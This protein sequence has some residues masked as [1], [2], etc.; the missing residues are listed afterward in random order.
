MITHTIDINCRPDD[1]FA[2]REQLEVAHAV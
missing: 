2:Y 1:A